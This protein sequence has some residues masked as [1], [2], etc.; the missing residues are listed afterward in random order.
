MKNLHIS[1]GLPTSYRPVTILLPSCYRP[2]TVLLPSCYRPVTVLLPS[3]YQYISA[4]ENILLNSFYVIISKQNITSMTQCSVNSA[5]WCRHTTVQFYEVTWTEPCNNATRST[6]VVLPALSP[7]WQRICVY[8]PTAYL[9]DKMAATCD[10]TVSCNVT[11]QTRKAWKLYMEFTE[12]TLMCFARD[13]VLDVKPCFAE[14]LVL[15]REYFWFVR[16]HIGSSASGGQVI[17]Q[18]G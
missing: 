16:S 9:R 3:C 5:V 10:T 17:R 14:G 2:V 18:E 12:K 15:L 6:S 11:Q 7:R 1:S 13:V 8:S 4:W